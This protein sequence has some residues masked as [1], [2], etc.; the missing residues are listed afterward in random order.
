MTLP[1]VPGTRVSVRRGVVH[2][3]AGRVADL[4]SLAVVSIGGQAVSEIDVEVERWRAPRLGWFGALRLPGVASST[5]EPTKTGARVRLGLVA[6]T[7]PGLVLAAVVRLLRPTAPVQTPAEPTYAPGLPASA[8][9]LAGW[10]RDVLLPEEKRDRHVR[11]SDT[12]VC[13]RE[14]GEDPGRTRTV[15]VGPTGWTVGDHRFDV[16]VDPAVHRPVGRRSIGPWPVAAARVGVDR[17][18]QAA[19]TIDGPDGPVVV[20]ADLDLGAVA[21]LRSVAAVVGEVPAR[22]AQQ[23]A[24]CGIVAVPSVD[25]LPGG[26]ASEDLAWQ[27]RSVH[28]R[29]HALR[30]HG[31]W[32]ALDAWP[33]VS[34]VLVTHRPEQIAHAIAQVSRLAYPR[35]EIVLGLHGDA[36]DGAVVWEAAQAVPHP[37]TIV[38]VDASLTLGEALQR[39]SDRAE[40]TLLTKMDDDDHYGAEHIWDLVLAREYSGAQIVGKTLDWVFLEHDDTTVFRPVYPAEKYASFVA[41]GTML[42]SRADLAAVGGWRPVPRSVDRALL[43][44]VLLDGGLVYR[45]HGLGYT[46]VRRDG[47]RTASVRDEHFLTRTEATFPGLLRDAALGTA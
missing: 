43:D 44:R 36:I 27:S 31:P 2:V 45:T 34:V 26:G 21:A 11:R 5:V 3:R 37:V 18:G 1:D 8:G 25:D 10:V 23:L 28:D 46:Y 19:V 13:G 30:A 29:R 14:P 6:P 9:L 40:G 22:L 33:T 38:A 17:D 16:S 4:A 7:D 47:G 35:L 20:G 15:V 24:A 12:L 41:G 39:C 32:S 42:V